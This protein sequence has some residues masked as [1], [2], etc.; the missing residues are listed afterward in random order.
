MTSQFRWP[1]SL[2]YLYTVDEFRP[3]SQPPTSKPLAASQPSNQR[4]EFEWPFSLKYLYT[5]DEFRLSASSRP[6]SPSPVVADVTLLPETKSSISVGVGATPVASSSRK[7]KPT[8]A[9][10]LNR[11]MW[12]SGTSSSMSTGMYSSRPLLSRERD[13]R[14]DVEQKTAEDVPAKPRVSYIYVMELVLIRE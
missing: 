8:R 5:V 6:Q 3:S 7:R 10:S 2:R 13:H 1:F 12:R 9:Q 11:N 4:R 14:L